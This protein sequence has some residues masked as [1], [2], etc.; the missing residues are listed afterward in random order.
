[1]DRAEVAR[2]TRSKSSKRLGPGLNLRLMEAGVG[3]S[4]LRTTFARNTG[5]PTTRGGV[6]RKLG[7]LLI[8]GIMSMVWSIAK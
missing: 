2:S 5:I 8:K 1:M 7:R 6:E 3:L 4:A